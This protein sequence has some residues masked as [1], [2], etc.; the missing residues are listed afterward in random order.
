MKAQLLAVVANSAD[1]DSVPTAPEG[2]CPH[3]PL[4]GLRDGPPQR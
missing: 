4:R 3:P 1:T 2:V